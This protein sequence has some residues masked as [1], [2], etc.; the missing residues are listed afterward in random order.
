MIVRFCENIRKLPNLHKE[1]NYAQV[2]E[3]V[4]DETQEMRELEEK[5]KKNL[6]RFNLHKSQITSVEQPESES[7]QLLD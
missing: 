7:Q 1:S 4:Q 6:E 2:L 3:N 5:V